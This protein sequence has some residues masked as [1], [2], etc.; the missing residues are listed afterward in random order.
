[1]TIAMVWS[2]DSLHRDSACAFKI[3]RSIAGVGTQQQEDLACPL[4]QR[5]TL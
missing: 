5:I 3:S 4:V 1:M 2:R